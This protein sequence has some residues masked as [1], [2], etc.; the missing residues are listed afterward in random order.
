VF[1]MTRATTTSPFAATGPFYTVGTSGSLG[2]GST[3]NIYALDGTGWVAV[4][5][6]TT[7]EPAPI[8]ALPRDPQNNATYYYGFEG[9]NTSKLF[10]LV[11]NLESTRFSQG[12]AEDKESTDGGGDVA[13]FEVGTT[14][15]F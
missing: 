11:A 6:N 1:Y 14:L 13:I 15:S 2:A 12:G 4:N 7:G 8:T 5:F 3:R 9:N 10:E